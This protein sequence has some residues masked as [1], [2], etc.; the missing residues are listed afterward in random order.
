[1]SAFQQKRGRGSVNHIALSPLH[2]SLFDI[3]FKK[4]KKEKKRRKEPGV[5]SRQ[6]NRSFPLLSRAAPAKM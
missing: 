3:K 2:A 1:M 6:S 5:W 4:E